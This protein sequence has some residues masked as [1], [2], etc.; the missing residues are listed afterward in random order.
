[1]WQYLYC[2]VCCRWKLPP[3]PPPPP[4]WALNENPSS[5]SRSVVCRVSVEGDMPPSA[6]VRD[7]GD[8]AGCQSRDGTEKMECRPPHPHAPIP[9]PNQP[10]PSLLQVNSDMVGPQLPSISTSL[11][12]SPLPLSLFRPAVCVCVHSEERAEK[13]HRE[14]SG[15][16]AGWRAPTKKRGSAWRIHA[17]E[18]EEFPEGALRR[19]WIS[20][21]C[22]SLHLSAAGDL[23][24]ASQR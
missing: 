8:S 21:F 14:G 7:A 19:C 9:I 13:K 10:P 15:G 18:H 24:F 3:P 6:S 2:G 5:R 12:L 20:L 1:M 17:E 11:L 4:P 23:S 22:V 16:R